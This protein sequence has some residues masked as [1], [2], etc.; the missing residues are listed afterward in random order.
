MPGIS[1]RPVGVAASGAGRQ[2]PAGPVG[3]QIVEVSPR[4]GLQN[5]SVRLPTPMK[6]ELIRRCAARGAVRI[7]VTG[8]ARPEVVP[9]LADAE[10][11]ARG[12]ADLDGVECSALVLNDRGYDRAVAAGITAVNMVV[13]ATETFSQ[14]NQRMS[15]ERALGTA[16]VLRDRAGRD[17]VRFSLTVGAAF[18][19]PFEGELPLPRLERLL[20]QVAA[21]SPDEISLADTIGVASPLDV[22]QRFALLAGLAPNIKRRAHFHDTRNTGVANSV[23][24]VQVGVTALDAPTTRRPPVN[25]GGPAGPRS[26]PGLHLP[27][28]PRHRPA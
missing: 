19:C 26:D 18:G 15:V 24:A 5:E 7:E 16:A 13:L 28:L 23:A 21:I 22:E 9:A 3:V 11:I 4:D 1:L 12:V 2:R 14:R 10:Q 20:T 8:F 27:L 17:G 25:P 6:L